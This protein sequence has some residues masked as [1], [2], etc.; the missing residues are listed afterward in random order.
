MSSFNISHID[1]ARREYA[2]SAV[3][4]VSLQV[5]KIFCLVIRVA[6]NFL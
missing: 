2:I 3:D 5:A 4:L 6:Y 1:L